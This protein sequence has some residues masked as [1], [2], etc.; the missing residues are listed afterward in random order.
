MRVFGDVAVIT[1]HV[2]VKLEASGQEIRVHPA[3]L[4]DYV[5]HKGQWQMVAHQT[6]RLSEP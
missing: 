3:F 6:T 5:R 4:N 1:S 2:R